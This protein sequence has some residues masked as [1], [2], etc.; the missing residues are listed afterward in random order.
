MS[1]FLTN[2]LDT[3]G[4]GGLL[5]GLFI[6]AMGLPFPGGVM[7]MFSGFLVNQDRLDFHT[8][9]LLAVLGFNLGA[10]LAFFIGRRVGEPL[11]DQYSRYLRVKNYNLE[12]ARFW[13]KRSAPLF[14]IAGRFVPMI[15]NMTPYLAGAS[16]LKWSHFLFYNFV[17]TILWVSI[18]IS[19]GMLFGHNWPRIAGY[20]NNKLP[21][22][23]VAM[24]AFYIAIKF[25][26][27]HV[28][29]FRSE[30]L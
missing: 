2:Y 17:F 9:F 5:G 19:V 28:Y 27:K 20:L 7:I 16:G 13:L 18:N 11:F 25:L 14:I 24:V 8:V 10:A 30:R 3:L 22:A 1:E 4:L 23:V 15:S 29:S 21:L 6:E 12:H 26:I